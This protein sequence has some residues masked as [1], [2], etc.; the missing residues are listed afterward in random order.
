M[1]IDR[2]NP[3][4]P[5][6]L[7]PT[8]ASN[9]TAKTP[10]TPRLAVT[11]TPTPTSASTSSQS[12]GRTVRS[13]NGSTPR[14]N[15]TA[16]HADVTPVKA[17][18]SSNV[19]P[20]SSSRKSR[21]GVESASSTPSSTPN[22]TPTSSRPASTIDFPQREQSLGYGGLGVNGHHGAQSGARPRSIPGQCSNQTTSTPRLLPSH[23]HN[24][25]SSDTS[26]VKDV[27]SLFFH[28]N[29]AKP[30]EQ[31]APVPV[32]QK[33]APVFFYANGKQNDTP[34][35]SGVSSPPLSSV[36]KSHPESKFFHADSL[37]ES[38]DRPPAL[39]PPPVSASPELIPKASAAHGGLSLRPPS[40]TKEWAHLSY[41]KGVSQVM[42][43]PIHS[44]N[45]VLSILSG[46][47][48][49]DVPDRS[50]RRS[51]ATSS[52]VRLGHAKSA[53]LSSIDSI[54]ELNKAPSNDLSAMTPSPLHTANRIV[55]NESLPDSV[56][57]A[58][59]P[60]MTTF[61][62]L[63]SPAPTSPIRPAGGQSAL[64]L[65]NE[66]AANARRERKVLD[67]EISNSSLLAINRS[68]EREVRKQKAELRRFRRMSRAGR[69][70]IDTVGSPH[71]TF[72]TTG[73]G[74]V[75]DLSDMSEEEEGAE[76]QEEDEQQVLVEEEELES[77]DSS[78]DE[79]TLSP[80]AQ[81]DRD[82]A[83]RLR[84]E[85]RL[86][87]DLSKHRGLLIDSQKMNQ[88]LKRCMGWT[89]QLIKDGRK[90]LEYQVRAS[91]VKLGG[92]VLV[93]DDEATYTEESRGLLSP[94]SPLHQAMDA[95]ESPFFAE[96]DRYI[97]RDSG[98]ALEGLKPVAPEFLA[99]LTPLGTPFEERIK[100]LHASI[101]ALEAS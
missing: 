39:T 69:F 20:R 18:L 70:S 52:V 31:P 59:S 4:N 71:D 77:S 60:P 73:L 9:R 28:A 42:R 67:L 53:S 34:R 93:T 25:P 90:A 78:F 17:F 5:R 29:D 62:G 8:L 56:A 80:T 43:P 41:R 88:S 10:I 55:S 65:M 27:S 96:S 44:R 35:K 16:A 45:S 84:D 100:H 6:P 95:L 51:S 40:P 30:H 74:H 68:L 32:P 3:N 37:P 99:D 50:R 61:S 7:K 11:P 21:V 76:A 57:S 26:S 54:A 101:D 82:E 94:W 64:E 97:D 79:S 92:R 1:P 22:A 12:G 13:S 98:V 24:Y 2:P 66:L 72:S 63:P 36:A 49:P 87:L 46:T 85:K 89:E 38:R 33:K 15:T 86:Q 75:G 83:H 14:A 58:P 81:A 47:S 91:D 23:I 48:T 19:T